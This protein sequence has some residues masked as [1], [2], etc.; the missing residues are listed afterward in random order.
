MTIETEQINDL[1]LLFE[2]M[3]KMGLQAIVDEVIEAHGHRQG[4][5]IGWTII[6]WLIHILQ[7]RNHC[8]N[9]VQK[10]VTLVPETLDRLTGESIEELD[11]TDD[12]LADVLRHL[13]DDEDWESIERKV[14]R[15][16]MRAYELP[17]PAIVRLDA[18]SGSVTHDEKTHTLFKRGWSKNGKTEVQFK[19]MMSTIDPLGLP[20]AVDV[21][22]GEKSDAPLYI[23]NYRRSKA[24][25]GKTGLLYVG[26]SKMS[27]LETRGTIDDGNDFYLAPLAYIG[28]T[29]KLLND[30]IEGWRSGKE[31]ATYIYW[32][33]DIPS[34]GTEPDPQ[35]AIAMGF[36]LV[37]PQTVVLG[38]KRVIW[39]E[40]CLVIR[41]M[42]YAESM[43]PKF[44][45]RLN[46]AEAALLRLTPPPSKGK[47]QIR[48]KKALREKIKAIEKK[49]Q[50]AGLFDIQFE[51]EV[52]RRDIQAY[53]DK[54]A[55]TEETVRYQIT[56]VSHNEDAVEQ[57]AARVGWRMYA[58]N[59]SSTRLNLTDAVLTYRNQYLAEQPFG[60][61]K[62]MS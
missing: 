9:V 32:P 45:K 1:P 3:Q 62:G 52:Q 15:L 40:R 35:T 59:A 57:A 22:S 14:G 26:D 21:V 16:V 53:K 37:H 38:D 27:A 6:I 28:E 55:R 41:S 23:P 29:P 39:Q 33:E 12:R 25:L 18:T 30:A 13:S 42:A 49:Y 44:W 17:E 8:M 50:V 56:S 46:R 47:R 11:F 19:T 4:L 10:W 36:E 61:L 58:T 24:I 34:D 5:S 48:D 20:I 51:R 2:L 31:E 54:P 7:E 60:R 43:L